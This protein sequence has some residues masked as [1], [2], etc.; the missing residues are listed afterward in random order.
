MPRL[1]G[2]RYLACFY[3]GRKNSTQYDNRI[4][5]FECPYC[6]ATN[7][8][9]KVCQPPQLLVMLYS[10]L[11][12]GCQNG[13]ITDPPVATEKEATPRQ[14]A[15][16][17][18]VSPPSSPTGN[19]TF[20]ATC[21]KNQHLLSASLAQYLPD[22]DDPD[23]AEREKGLHRFRRNQ[24]RLYPQICSK[25]EPKVRQRLEQAAYTAKTDL[26]RRMLDRSATASK[27]MTTAG[28]LERFDTAGKWLWIAGF[29]LQL[30][31]HAAVVHGLLL[32]YLLWAEVDE[33]LFTFQ[34]LRIC[35]PVVASLPSAER[36]LGWSTLASIS[37]AWWNPRVAQISRGFTRH[38]SGVTKWYFFQAMAV[39]MR[40][41]LQ[42]MDLTTPDPL[43][44][45]K[46][47]AGHAL[48]TVIALLVSPLLPCNPAVA[49][50][51]RSLSLPHGQSESTWRRCSAPPPRRPSNAKI[52]PSRLPRRA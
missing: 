18:A 39:V 35:A 23:Y 26:L 13:D 29:V 2:R 16:S 1:L 9:D 45:N 48:A 36:L 47:A 44:L 24:E 19:S 4:R 20:C 8:L 11:T 41:C 51:P 43:L 42:R 52:R 28:W 17:R 40:I 25:C 22:P 10:A 7:Y 37:G 30:T 32:Q 14:Y 50:H 49:Y 5:R 38:I 34:L 21:L 6:D 15:V 27:S 31:W 3:C 12:V 46:H 33:S